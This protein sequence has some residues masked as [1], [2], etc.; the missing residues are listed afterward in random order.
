MVTDDSCYLDA[1]LKHKNSSESQG[2]HS[3]FQDIEDK[4]ILRE[5]AAGT[6][7]TNQTTGSL[8]DSVA[9]IIKFCEFITR[10]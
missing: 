6:I 4:Y 10:S 3:T 9:K 8:L 1:R 7:T 5:S 2:K